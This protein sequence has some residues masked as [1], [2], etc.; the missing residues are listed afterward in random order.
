[1]YLNNLPREI[2]RILINNTIAIIEF[3]QYTEKS[4]ERMHEIYAKFRLITALGC[5]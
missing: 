2:N 1:M 3:I 4:T 5:N